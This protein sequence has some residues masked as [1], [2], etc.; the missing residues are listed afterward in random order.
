MRGASECPHPKKETSKQQG[1]SPLP[2]LQKPT[3]IRNYTTPLRSVE[4][5]TGSVAQDRALEKQ[6]QQAPRNKTGW[7]LPLVMTSST[8]LI[9][10]QNNLK[11][12]VKGSTEL[13]NTRNGTHVV[14]KEMEDYATM[15]AY[16]ES[17]GL[18]LYTF[19]PK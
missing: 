6:Q 14:T 7:S 2:L 9:H 3:V 18:H 16:F 12:I 13:Q 11:G 15:K 4:M 1:N 5:D 17:H 10:L 19:T 8:N